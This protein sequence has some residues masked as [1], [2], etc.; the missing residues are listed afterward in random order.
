MTTAEQPQID[1]TDMVNLH[2]VFRNA[3]TESVGWLHDAAAA[4]AGRV[5]DVGSYFDNVL[6]LLHVHHEGEDE[7]MTPRLVERGDV[8]E[9]A[10]VRRVAGQHPDA[11]DAIERAEQAVAQWRADPTDETSAT[12]ASA[13]TAL[14]TT[15]GEHLDDEER[16]VLP[17]AARYLSQPEWAELPRHGMQHF[18]G[19]KIW[20]VLGLIQEQMTPEQIAH[21]QAVMP[22]PVADWWANEGRP[23]FETFVTG[24]RG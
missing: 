16:S 15:L 4:D 24:L 10:E 21:M 1:T 20:L 9:V 17:I 5:D 19:D 3:F 8:D 14:G 23:Q 2:R 22:P 12:A 11:Q 18:D 6:R 7:L 13:L